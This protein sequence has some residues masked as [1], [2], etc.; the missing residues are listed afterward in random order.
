MQGADRAVGV[1]QINLVVA[2]RK[3]LAAD[4]IGRLGR[5][6]N[7]QRRD[8]LR[9]D[10]ARARD[11]R[12]FLLVFGRDRLHHARPG[13]RRHAIRA[14]VESRHVERDAAR[15]PDNAH[16]GRR[17]IGLAEIADQS[18]RRCHVHVGAGI[19]LAEMRRAGAAHDE[20]AVQVDIDDI[21][22]IRPAH[23]MK[24]A[25]AQDAGIVHQNIDAAEGVERRL[26]DLVA[27]SRIADRQR[28]GD[29]L[30]AG[31]LD[32]VNH[33]MRRAG[34]GA[35]AFQARADV[36]DHDARTFVRH[37]ERNAA[38]DAASG[39]GDDRDFAV[40]DAGHAL[41]SPKRPGRSRRSSSASPILRLR[42]TY[43][44]PRSR[45]SR[46]AATGRAGRGWC[47]SPPL[48]GGA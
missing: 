10:L 27:V 19:L 3:N 43:C 35:G 48:R 25:V 8:F 12:F 18:G 22:P 29:R 16:L 5:Q 21:R 33:R 32:L 20:A 24:N 40:D 13:E 7:H 15:Q 38:P 31:C 47:T 17:I 26:H 46:I 34:V 28:R 30:T 2:R 1:E 37:Q 39:A 36:A 11:S 45:R 9:R 4:A 44:L 42:P 14:H 41:T 6:I 23:A